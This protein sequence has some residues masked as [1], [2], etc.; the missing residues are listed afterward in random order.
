MNLS[1]WANVLW[2]A[3]F[4]LNAALIIVLFFKR[5]YRIVPW[6]T[7][8]MT[9]EAVYT[10]ALYFTYRFGS[11]HAY[12][13]LYLTA[14]FLDVALQIAVILEIA[15]FL[16]RRSGRW[17]EGARLRLVLMGGLAPLLALAMAWFMQPAA[18]TRLDSILARSSLFTTILVC[19]LFTGILT[20]SQSLGLGL[21]NHVMRESYGFIIW[22]LVAF[23]TD[24]LHAYWG[25][26]GHFTLLENVRIAV[27]QG[28]L[29]YWCVAFWLPE[30]QEEKVP[31]GAKI[32]LNRLAMELECSKS[33]R[34][35]VTG[36]LRK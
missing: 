18:N 9:V 6:F 2:A 4:L 15:G 22:N 35:S 36:A 24:S 11:K 12:E 31:E 34:A 10:V 17:V 19:V 32:D 20:A 14:D 25:T 33:N 3:G 5:R 13:I 1:V 16:L 21:R 23:L 28:T 7:A 30:K 8:W 27:F 26:L 29:V